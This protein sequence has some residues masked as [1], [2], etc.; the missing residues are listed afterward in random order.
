MTREHFYLLAI[1]IN[2]DTN[3]L[4]VATRGGQATFLFLLTTAISS[5]V[6]LPYGRMVL[7]T[8]PYAIEINLVGC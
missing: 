6:R 2:T 4:S 7:M 8:M 1:A 3:L 5:L